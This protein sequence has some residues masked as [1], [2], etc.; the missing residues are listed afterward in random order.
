MSA[1]RVEVNL[2]KI[3][4]NVMEITRRLNAIGV[5]VTAVTKAVCGHPEIARAM[6]DGGAVSLAESRLKNVRKLRKTGILC[7]VTLIRTPMLS[8]ASEIVQ[9]CETSYNTE[10]S[11]IKALA[12]EAGRSALVHNII[13]MVN[14]GDNREGI[15]PEHVAKIANQVTKISNVKLTGIGT[16]FACLSNV[17][18]SHEQMLALS[19]IAKEVESSCGLTI[20][21]VSGGNSSSLPYILSKKNASR[22][23]NLR[24][25]EAILLGVDPVTGAHINKMHTD[26]F[27]LI[28][29][30]IETSFCP[31]LLK[32]GLHIPALDTHCMI[33]NRSDVARLI[34]ALGY[35]DTDVSGLSMPSGVT[36]MGATSDHVIIQAD[37]LHLKLGS[38]MKFQMNYKALMHAMAAPDVDIKVL[39]S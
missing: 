39:H 1:P 26:A 27:T 35:Q 10:I 16:N 23:N 32:L 12:A 29:E 37:G 25:G 21:I 8:E 17:A 28:A 4:E 13:L 14:M 34:L 15:L 22:V 20:Q 7:P 9:L 30:V 36:L 2:G 18:P 3:R 19:R 38:E 11:A 6:L 5:E 33:S 24:L 31:T